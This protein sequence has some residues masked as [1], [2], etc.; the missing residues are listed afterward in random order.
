MPNTS[1]YSNYKSNN[2]KKSTKKNKK[3]GHK[4]LKAVLI[5]LLIMIL[6]GIGLMVGFVMSVLNGAGG[7]SK[8]DFEISS[9]TTVVYDKDGK[10]YASLYSSE[11]RMY[12][13]LSEMSPY[14]PKAVIAIED[15]RFE[16][17]MGI[18]IKRTGAAVVNWVLRGNSD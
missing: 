14:L 7:L 11:N 8:S 1:E 3:N 13:S 15:Q 2:N 5:I 10:E 6:I 17:H 4:I 12:S 16:T 18:D 9:L